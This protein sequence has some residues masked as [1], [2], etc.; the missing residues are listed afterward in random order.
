M[1]PTL[2]SV[3]IEFFIH[4]T[5]D[6]AKVLKTVSETLRIP[7]D[8]F[9]RTVL[10]GHFGNPIIIFKAHPTGREAD[11][12]V[13]KLTRFLIDTEKKKLILNMLS[14]IDEHGALYLR[15]DKQSLFTNR[16][17]QSQVDVV[18]IKIKPRFKTSLQKTIDL[19]TTMFTTIDQSTQPDN[20]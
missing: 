14:Q 6:E 18:R 4:A 11:T 9:G 13:E 16:L 1:K 15:V 20:E 12:F 2:A 8:A 7:Q 19:Y 5:E 17:T 10:E 3:D